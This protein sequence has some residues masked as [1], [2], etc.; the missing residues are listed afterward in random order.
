MEYIKR[1]LKLSRV[2]VPALLFVMIL[3]GTVNVSAAAPGRW[4]SNPGFD[5]NGV[6]ETWTSNASDC[7][8]HFTV[9]V[10]YHDH[11]EDGG[12]GNDVGYKGQNVLPNDKISH[13]TLGELFR[14]KV[15]VAYAPINHAPGFA[16]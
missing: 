10:S 15:G 3:S 6:S 1:A 14:N 12:I 4:V 5:M 2:I 9:G 13:I 8:Q 16:D 7:I 11:R